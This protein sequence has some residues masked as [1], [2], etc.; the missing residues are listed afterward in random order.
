MYRVGRT[1]VVLDARVDA[2]PPFRI[3]FSSVDELNVVS[4]FRRSPLRVVAEFK[5]VLV[6]ERCSI[7]SH[8][9]TQSFVV[10]KSKQ[11]LL[12][13]LE[14]SLHE[15]FGIVCPD[16]SSIASDPDNS[17]ALKLVTRY[18]PEPTGELA[19]RIMTYRL[20]QDDEPF[21]LVD[22]YDVDIDATM[23][24]VKRNDQQVA[25]DWV[26][27][28]VVTTKRTR[29]KESI[30]AFA[31]NMFVGV[32]HKPKT[33]T[34]FQLDLNIGKAQI[35]VP[36]DRRFTSIVADASDICRALFTIGQH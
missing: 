12:N 34:P 22:G 2:Q 17:T 1:S 30:D 25:T 27:N 19:G 26:G 29:Q 20:N 9:T 18:I 3:S 15:N 4:I 16:D 23:D 7:W 8:A 6:H 36:H 32:K 10:W 33:L 11:G 28:A 13:N 35:E 21:M 31:G 24:I 5:E 14:I